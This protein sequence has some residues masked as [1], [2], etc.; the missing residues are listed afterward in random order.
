M[1]VAI[2]TKFLGATNYKPSRIKAYTESGLSK[3]ISWEY[4]V[5]VEENHRLAAQALA[6]RMGWCGK[7]VGGG[8]KEGYAFVNADRAFAHF[9]VTSNE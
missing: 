6:F 5:G 9:K 3:T 4:G 8:T 2:M 7:W 1:S